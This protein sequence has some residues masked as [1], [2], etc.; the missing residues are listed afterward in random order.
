[1][2]VEEESYI[3]FEMMKLQIEMKVEVLLFEETWRCEIWRYMNWNGKLRQG[4]SPWPDDVSL[5]HS[6]LNVRQD[7][8]EVMQG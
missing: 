6:L 8:W 2:R 7:G 3:C 5:L 1:M 4:A